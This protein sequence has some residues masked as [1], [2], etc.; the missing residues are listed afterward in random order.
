MN[1][2]EI[3]VIGLGFVG[4]TLALTFTNKN[5][6]IVGVEINKKTVMSLQKNQPHFFENGLEKSL[7]R[8]NQKELITFTDEMKYATDC[9]IFI[10]T[11]G[12]P[13][14]NK[15]KPNFTFIKRCIDEIIEIRPKNP[16][17]VLRSTVAVGTTREVVIKLFKDAHIDADIAMCP[18]RTMAGF[19]MDEIADLPQIISGDSD[20]AVA[21]AQKLFKIFSKQMI[22]VSSLETAELIKLTDNSSRDLFFA[23]SNELA[24]IAECLNLNAYEI[25][26]AANNSYPRTNLALPG[27]VGGPC[28]EKDP[29]ILYESLTNKNYKP[30]LFYSGRMLN[31][32][33]V[34]VLENWIKQLDLKCSDKSVA[35]LGL[36]FKGDPET[37]DLRGSIAIDI[38]ELLFQKKF[39]DIILFDPIDQTYEGEEISAKFPPHKLKRSFEDSIQETDIAIITNNHRFFSNYIDPNTIWKLNPEIQIFDFWNNFENSLSLENQNKY[40]VFGINN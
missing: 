12:T 33:I 20:R 37:S 13:L 22:T 6:K 26:K 15:N 30:E 38:A 1:E 23:I 3:C 25:I 31:K 10:I 2:K 39:K 16:L 8:A 14:D 7:K 36:A 11:V 24:H 32:N 29:L 4:L 5:K 40:K 21:R 28:L 35:I 19:A 34:N 17:I 18:E 27:P 9:N